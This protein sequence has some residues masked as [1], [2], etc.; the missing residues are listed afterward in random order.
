M[1]EEPYAVLETLDGWLRTIGSANDA[2]DHGYDEDAARMRQDACDAIRTLLAEH[3]FLVGLFPEL[4]WELE[5]EHILT[6]G[7]ASLSDSVVAQINAM[8]TGNQ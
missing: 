3:A 1:N 2:E 6:F 7:W 5:T 4:R 8:K